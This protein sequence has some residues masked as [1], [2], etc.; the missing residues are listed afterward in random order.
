MRSLLL[1]VALA[2]GCASARLTLTPRAPYDQT[3]PPSLT[4]RVGAIMVLPPRG[5][6]RGQ[7]SELA[8][9]ERV[10]LAGGLRVISSGVT[11]RVVLDSG[12]TRV[13]TAANLSDLERALVLARDSNADV[14]L[15]VVELDWTPG[16]RAFVREGDKF[17]EVP[18]G[19][20][21]HPASLARVHEAVFRFQARLINVVNAEIVMAVDIMQGTSRVTSPWTMRI[22]SR[23]ASAEIDT[24]TAERRRAAVTQV[25]RAFLAR[26]ART[27]ESAT[28]AASPTTQQ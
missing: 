8:E 25:M 5:S 10:L 20:P 18:R 1:M 16:T 17:R 7:A 4:T 14:L 13:E 26:L 21:V 23:G 11:G 22:S 3:V 2:S 15:Q 6:E 28:P 12:G 24:N 19:T 27:S 9:V